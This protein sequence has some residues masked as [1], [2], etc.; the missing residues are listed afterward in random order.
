GNPTTITIT[1][2]TTGLNTQ[3]LR[4]NSTEGPVGTTVNNPTG[5]DSVTFFEAG[6]GWTAFI[7]TSVLPPSAGASYDVLVA[8]AK[9]VAY[10][11]STGTTTFTDRC[12]T[13]VVFPNDPS[14]DEDVSQ[15]IAVPAG[16][17]FYGVAVPQLVVSTNGFLTFDTTMT[18]PH[19]TNLD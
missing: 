17:S 3:F 8:P 5:H 15:P 9:P 12:V 2:K 19:Y 14:G 13:P 16:F 11:Q 10:A 1:P 4:V 7:V 18:D 6:N